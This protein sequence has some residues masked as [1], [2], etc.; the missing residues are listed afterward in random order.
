M[1]TTGLENP[2]N[3]SAGVSMPV[4]INSTTTDRATMS[5]RTFPHTKKNTANRIITKTR[6]IFISI[7]ELEQ[8]YKKRTNPDN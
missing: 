7:S 4:T 2:D 8:R 6:R 5:D 1:I 3:P